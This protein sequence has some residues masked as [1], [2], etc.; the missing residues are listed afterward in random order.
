MKVKATLDAGGY[1]SDEITNDLVRDRLAQPDAVS[2]F[3]LDGYP[4]TNAQVDELDAMLATSGT[5]LDAVAELCVD[6]DEIVHRLV[7][8]A[9]TSGRSDDT[10][11]VIRRR[12]QIYRQET[13]PLLER[14][15]S[16]GLLVQVDGL[17]EIDE[18]GERLIAAIDA[19][20]GRAA[21]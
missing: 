14:Y 10:E 2:G 19:A 15:R 12:Q 21:S 16:R 18:I 6:H 1:V 13:A 17:G 7:L 20:T 4:R 11:E 5:V 9:Q 3:L 8:R